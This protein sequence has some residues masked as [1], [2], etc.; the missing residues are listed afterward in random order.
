MPW[1][2]SQRSG[3]LSY[4]G[5][6]VAQGH[7]GSGAGRNNPDLQHVPNA[8]PIPRGRYSIGRPRAS[9]QTGAHVLDLSPLGHG[10]HGR[11]PLQIHG[12]ARSAA[13]SNGCIVLTR[14][15]RQRISGSGDRILVVET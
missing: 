14:E 7:S 15:I 1:E 10:A 13:T 6:P 5:Q 3:Q 11:A 12:D 2:Y 8:G 4:N 9:L